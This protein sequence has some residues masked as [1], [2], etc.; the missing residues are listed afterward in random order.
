MKNNWLILVFIVGIFVTVLFAFNYQGDEETIPL[1]EIFSD[2][3]TIPIDIE[4]EFVSPK[5]EV[6]V[7]EKVKPVTE[8]TSK[9]KSSIQKD[10]AQKQVKIS[11]TKSLEE[12]KSEFTFTIQVASFKERKKAEEVLTTLEKKGHAGH[13]VTRDLGSKGV[14]YRVYVG[15]FNTKEEASV[16]LK[17]L[18]TMYKDSFVLVTRT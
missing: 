8:P 12:N 2:E 1:S 17:E 6:Q 13:I 3:E 4:Y 10:G 7:A 18:K 14:W 15:N 5:E 9:E 16:L 11:P